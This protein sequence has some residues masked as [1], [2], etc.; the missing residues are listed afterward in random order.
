MPQEDFYIFILH[1]M[2]LTI[3]IS[4][5]SSVSVI[6]PVSGS[7]VMSKNIDQDLS[8]WPQDPDI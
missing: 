1:N 6:N 7:S 4:L 8:C 5:K 3:S 2:Q